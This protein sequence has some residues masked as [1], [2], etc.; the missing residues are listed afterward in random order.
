MRKLW[1]SWL[2]YFLYPLSF[3][4]RVKQF[5]NEHFVFGFGMT[6]QKLNGNAI[7]VTL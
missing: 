2:L 3:S 7:S 4:P 5:Y 1:I 6:L